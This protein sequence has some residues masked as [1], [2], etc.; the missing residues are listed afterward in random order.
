M[1]ALLLMKNGKI[2]KPQSAGLKKPE[3]AIL[4]ISKCRWICWKCDAADLPR[5]E[6]G[7]PEKVRFFPQLDNQR[8]SLK[9]TES[10]SVINEAQTVA[11]PTR[12]L[13]PTQN[14]QMA[15]IPKG[16]KLFCALP[17]PRDGLID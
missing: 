14:K 17:N 8:P 5:H 1:L 6:S 12:A 15:E 16:R 7:V 13:V 3:H 2:R 10:I 11:R 4:N 9:D